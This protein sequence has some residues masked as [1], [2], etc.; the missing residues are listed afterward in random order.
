MC[1]PLVE[2]G[3][4]AVLVGLEALDEV[5]VE[6]VHAVGEDAHAVEQ[7]GD[8]DG[9]E[10]VQLELAVHATNG[11]S[12]VVTHNLSADHGERLALGGV[13]LSGH[14]GR[15][16]L[17]LGE[18]QL[19]ETAAGS[20]SEVTDILGNLEQRAGQGVQGAGC[21][22]DRVVGSENL[23]LVGGSLE[24]GA[25][26]LADLGSDGLVEAL[27]GV[28]TGTDSGT[29]LSQEAQVGDASLNALDVAVELGN[30]A[31]EL[32]AKSQ[33]SGVLQVSTANLDDVLELVD[34]D[35]ES[36]TESLKGRQKGLLELDNGGNVHNGGEGVVGGGGHVDVVVGV[37]RLLGAHGTTED[38]NGTV[39]DDLVGVHVGLGAGTS[40]PDN[41]REVVQ[42]LT[43]SNLSSGLL[44]GLT[45]LGVLK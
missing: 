3:V 11:G 5:G 29:T 26:Q 15:A 35:L 14:D 44:D 6:A 7:V 13:D 42:Q 33:R 45:D 41:Q 24:L 1:I 36:V 27:E 28:Q 22:D 40:L 39:G 38:L 8:H 16:G 17:V 30:V 34:L 37:D 19:A 18:A 31:G 4:N 43:L 21:L 2:E 9:L 23:E 25:G 20:G 10:D 32:L 12:D